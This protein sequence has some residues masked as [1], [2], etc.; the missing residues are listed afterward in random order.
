M[1][2][3]PEESPNSTPPFSAF[4]NWI[5]LSGLVIAIGGFFSFILLLAMDILRRDGNPYVGILTFVV[6]PTFLIIGLVL[7]VVGWFIQHR[8]WVK[9]AKGK[10]SPLLMIDLTRA[11]N[12]HYL[13]AFAVITGVFLLLSAT[14]SYRAYHFAESIQFC[15]QACHTPMGPEFVTYQNSPHA[16][17]GC[18]ACH[19]GPGA[20]PFVKAKL[21]GVRQLWATI[22]AHYDRPIKTPKNLRPAQE[23]CE[24]CH[25]PKRFV[26]NLDRT[27][28]R[29]LSDETNTATSVRLLLQV[30]G[31]DPTHG[32][33]GGIHWHMNLANKVEYKYPTTNEHRQVIPWVRFTDAQ[34][35]V[36][37][38]QTTDFKDDPATYT[39]RTMDCM[40]CHNRP[41]HHLRPPNI[42]IDLAMT[43]GKID[44]TIPL[45]KSNLVELLTKNYATEA[46]ALQQIQTALQTAYPNEPRIKPVIAE[47]QQIYTNNF[48]PEMKAD[49]RAYPD[50][51][52]H[53]TWP[54]CFRCHDGQHKTADGKRQIGASGCADC[55]IILAQGA[56]PQLDQLNPRGHKFAHPDSSSEGT[57]PDCATCHSSSQ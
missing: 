18:T 57:D 2:Y 28:M 32:P 38:Y 35:I 42:S 15:G 51:I 9:H 22:R 33:V 8:H 16:R 7:I 3:M 17:V 43:L 39:T 11:R 37:E 56:G 41:A 26:G 1:S 24:K 6:A 36:T 47:A 5:N 12:R 29:F 48:F 54:G 13:A 14:G 20:V 21:N 19:I 55:H 4:R 44:P 23:T 45:I 25:W 10:P 46:E 50:N 49:W 30:G 34:G 52:G 53:K 27:Y 40:D 31:G